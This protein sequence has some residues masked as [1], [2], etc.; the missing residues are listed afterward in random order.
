MAIVAHHYTYVIGVDTHAKKH[1]FSI[2]ECPTGIEV[3]NQAFANTTPGHTRAATW[4]TKHATKDTANVLIVVEGTASYGATLTRFLQGKGYTVV[5]AP[6][7]DGKGRYQPKTDKIDAYHIAWRALRLEEN[8]LTIPRQG[9]EREALRILMASRRQLT[10]TKT[11]QINALT[12]L[13]RT[14]DVGVDARRPLTTAQ[15]SGLARLENVPGE[16]IQ[17]VIA[18]QE[19]RRWAQSILDLGKC[20]EENLGQI[21]MIVQLVAPLLLDLPGIGPFAAG[22]IIVSFSH[23]GRVRSEAAFASLAGVCPIPAC[24][25]NTVRYRLSRGGDRALN[26]ALHMAV[27]VRMRS[28]EETRAYVEKRLGEGKTKREVIRVLKRYLARRVYRLLT[29]HMRA[30]ETV[31]AS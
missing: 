24:S 11:A 27:L 21:K 7:P 26:Y 13:V 16:D 17:M 20:L 6:R 1:V 25:G 31:L 22:Q 8:A 2:L 15:I 4:I 5:E 29:R 28:D 10:R 19:A 14:I 18:K 23:A 12:A 30:E 9:T 3:I